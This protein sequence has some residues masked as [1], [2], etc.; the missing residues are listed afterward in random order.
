M[1]MIFGTIIKHHCSES[2]KILKDIFYYSIHAG[3][4]FFN[5]ALIT[6]DTFL[7][8]P[9]VDHVNTN[10]IINHIPD[11]SI[12]LCYCSNTLNNSKIQPYLCG[13]TCF[14]YAGKLS[15]GSRY[16]LQRKF[17]VIIPSGDEAE[18]FL[19]KLQDD[20]YMDILQY[21]NV[22]F[23]GVWTKYNT[24]YAVRN[25]KQGGYWVEKHGNIYFSSI[26]NMFNGKNHI[27]LNDFELIPAYETLVIG[28]I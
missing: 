8:S 1:C 11:K 17:S 27:Y 26:N 3:N 7:T 12:F 20:T 18:V 19:I 5:Y 2:K 13:N 4:K 15:N 10:N 28:K 9:N 21:P 14:L 23:F 6:D 16:D 25:E 24:V 22:K